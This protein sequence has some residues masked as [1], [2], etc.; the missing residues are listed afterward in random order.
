MNALAY[1]QIDFAI[2]FTVLVFT[3]E[4]DP[5]NSCFS[6]KETALDT[7]VRTTRHQELETMAGLRR[8]RQSTIT[9]HVDDLGSVAVFAFIECVE[10]TNYV[11]L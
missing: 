7:V 1:H 11:A 4:S 8:A 9:H 2:Q 10:H 5:W 6:V 3:S